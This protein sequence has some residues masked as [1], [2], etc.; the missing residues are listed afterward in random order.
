MS[1]PLDVSFIILLF[2]SNKFNFKRFF[3]FT[4]YISSKETLNIYQT[5]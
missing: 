4:P 1:N 3:V 5:P 2:F